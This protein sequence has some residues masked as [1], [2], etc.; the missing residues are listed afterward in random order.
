MRHWLPRFLIIASLGLHVLTAACYI[1]QPDM[2]A[3][4]TV[5]PIWIWGLLGLFF[6][7]L[8]FVFWRARLSLILVVLWSLTILIASDEAHALARIGRE[9]PQPGPSKPFQAQQTLRICTLNWGTKN[10]DKDKVKQQA[11]II[12]S[13]RPDILFLQEIHPWQARLITDTLYSGGGDY[14]SGVNCAIMTRWK[15]ERTLQ[16]PIQ[17]SQ[18]L[19]LKLPSTVEYLEGRLI[20]CVN[21]NLRSAVTDMRLWRRSC[22]QGHS[23][24]RKLQR[25]EVSSSLNVLK[26]TTPFP[27]RPAIVAGDFNSPASDPLHDLLRGHFNDSF[28]EA[29]TGWANTW[30]RR[31]PL[32]RIDYIYTNP[33]LK[34]V[35]SKT[36]IVPAS[37]HRMLVS[38]FILL[39]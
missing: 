30:H 5:Y 26:N 18:H 23:N 36:V 19:T 1:R 15:I 3:A 35:R 10:Y 39:P 29:G 16:N 12:A 34:A 13:Y 32:H 37:D 4:V 20:D 8:A 17:H 11:S 7:A 27:T 24:N 31:I 9:A 28:S 38:D 21:L 2:M 33:L 25:R 6:A 14:R 22:W